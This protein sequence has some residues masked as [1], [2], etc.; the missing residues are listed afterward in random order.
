MKIGILDIGTNSIHLILAE[1]KKDLHIEVLDRAK[2]FTRLG[3]HTFKNNFLSQEA[4]DRGI[5]TLR[6][7]KKLAEIRGIQ[8]IK[9]VATSAVREAANGGDFL[10][11]I[12]QNLGI[13]VKVIT[14]DEEARLIHLAVKHSIPFDQRASLIVDI[15]GGS[16]EFIIA[17]A[18]EKLASF[19]FKLG[20]IRLKEAFVTHDPLTKSEL[21]KL[22]KHIEKTL[23]PLWAEIKKHKVFRAIGTSG[24]ISNLVSLAHFKKSSQAIHTPN[25]YKIA[26][27][28]LEPIHQLLIKSTAKDRLKMR[29]LDAERQDII[30]TASMVMNVLFKKSKISELL[31]CQEAIREGM[32]YDYIEKNKSKIELEALIPNIR[33]RSV[34]KLAKKC[35]FREEHANQI[36]KLSLKLFDQTQ[37]LHKLSPQA[38]ELLHYSSLLHDI[39]YHISYKKHHRHSHYLIKNGNLNGFTE[40]EIEIMANIARYHYK[41]SPKK[42]QDDFLKLSPEEQKIILFG[43]AIVRLADGLD[44]SHF[45]VIQDLNC[46]IKGNL[47]TLELISRGD[48]EL[49]IWAAQKKKDLFEEVFQ[50]KVIL[51]PKKTLRK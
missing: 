12:D 41:S 44:R 33:F 36:C 42:S 32:I 39:G 37:T 51:S 38:R 46:N 4:I 5:S 17:N 29:G 1:I 2:E 3:E 18:K 16:V 40:G 20:A 19:S 31:L 11:L 50:K 34:M 25:N 27:K 15:G 7:F 14:G 24:S 47:I 8:K 22:E 48:P 6:R 26:T 23:K 13:K 9:A 43:A 45:S 10:D 21:Q 28:D 49:E 30:I 35:D